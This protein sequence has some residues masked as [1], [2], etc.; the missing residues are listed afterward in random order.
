MAEIKALAIV[1]KVYLYNND[2]LTLNPLPLLFKYFNIIDI[3]SILTFAESQ[4]YN[5][6]LSHFYGCVFEVWLA[7]A[8]PTANLQN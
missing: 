4:Y 5:M 7:T 8:C 2:T 3:A 6:Y 1:A